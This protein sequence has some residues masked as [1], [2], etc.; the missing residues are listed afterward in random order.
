ME[1][2][3]ALKWGANRLKNS[4]SSRLDAEVLL[5]FI[6]KTDKNFLYKN[7]NQTVKSERLKG[8]REIIGQ[9]ANFVPVAYL[10]RQK[11]FLGLLF[12]VNRSVLIPRPETE[13]LVAR[14]IQLARKKNTR[15][16]YDVGTG[17][18]NIAVSLA[19]H[20]PKTA[21]VAS[22][23]CEKALKVAAKNAAQ[24]KVAARIRFVRSDLASHIS[25]AKFIVANLPYV[26]Q[27]Y[28]VSRD[29]SHEPNKALF[30]GEDG[31]DLYRRFFES[32][33]F[34]TFGGICLIELGTRQIPA[35]KKWL[36]HNFSK[37]SFTP[38]RG[39]DGQT[40]GL[41]LNFS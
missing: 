4:L 38:L 7:P 29:I 23:I 33:I 26:P 28:L 22:D 37:V 40:V 2:K 20:L 24:H 27:R 14:A 16:I 18:G 41:E 10:I 21:I 5:A 30:A 1:I 39:I 19:V 34:E 15:K 31:L 6:L 8:Y 9:R 35:I 36:K 13:A 11:E 32:P 3:D 25:S 12:Y 17:S